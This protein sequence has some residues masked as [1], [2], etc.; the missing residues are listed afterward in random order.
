MKFAVYIVYDIFKRMEGGGGGGG[1][2]GGAEAVISTTSCT[3][4]FLEANA[5]MS[6]HRIW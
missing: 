2:G 4:G 6:N 1:G 3:F 5:L